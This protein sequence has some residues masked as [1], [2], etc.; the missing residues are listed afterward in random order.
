MFSPAAKPVYSHN[1]GRASSASLLDF[2]RKA[3][4]ASDV[5]ADFGF[6]KRRSRDAS[7]ISD[8]ESLY[9][10]FSLDR[11]TK[12]RVSLENRLNSDFFAGFLADRSL[13]SQFLN[14]NGQKIGSASKSAKPEDTIGF[15]TRRL[16]PGVYYLQLKS[17]FSGDIKYK[18][19][20]QTTAN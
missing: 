18:L 7:V 10:K 11:V 14:S 19:E 6:I 15:V 12:I 20:L 5:I 4:A 16:N 17:N 13:F 9:Y 8:K 3:P 1:L 2:S